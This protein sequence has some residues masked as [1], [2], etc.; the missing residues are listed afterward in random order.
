[1]THLP[2]GDDLLPTLLT[3]AHEEGQGSATEAYERRGVHLEMT[4]DEEGARVLESRERGLAL[5]LLRGGRIGFAAAVPEAAA[6]LPEAARQRLSRARSRRWARLPATPAGEART[7]SG[8]GEP[9]LPNE[10]AVAS[11]LTAFREALTTIGHGSVSVREASVSLGARRERLLSST[12]RDVSWGSQ[13]AT[14]V[15]TVV[16]RGGAGRF[17]SRVVGAAARAEDLPVSRLARH[18]V[19]RVLL[20][21][22]GKPFAG[23]RADLLLDP[24]VGAHLVG[25]LAPLFH[26]DEEEDLLAART[27]GGRDALAA[28]LVTLIDDAA[29]PGGLVRTERDGEGSLKGRTVLVE[30][31][32]PIGRLTDAS[33]ASRLGRPPTGNAVRASWSEPPRIGV[34]NFFVDPS[35]GVS[36]L[37]LLQ[38]VGR[39]LYAAV[40]LERPEVD[41]SADRF[42]LA[43]AGFLLEKGRAT[44]KVSDAILSGR[45]SELL[46]AVAGL[47]DDLKFVTGP[48]G[49]FGCPTLFVPRWKSS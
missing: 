36:P 18:A 24:H 47:G 1:M 10:Q 6:G 7:G 12:G 45:L 22:Q 9:E 28:P 3:R 8:I 25:R 49:G 32:I 41:L 21:L 5:R 16:G 2:T 30:R 23:G 17:L 20:P 42:R 33:S 44:E 34:T 14:L 19:D 4:E 26:G 40:L 43:V 48:G 39:G 27:R 31:G 38:G 15:A 35:P 37:E 13:M 46:R 11:I 29:E